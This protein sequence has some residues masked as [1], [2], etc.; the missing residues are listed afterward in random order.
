MSQTNLLRKKHLLITCAVT[1]CTIAA[2][3]VVVYAQSTPAI[4][5]MSGNDVTNSRNQPAEHVIQ[6]SNVSTLSPKWTFTTQGDVSATP[7]LDSTAVYAA[8][9]AGN[10]YAISRSAGQQLWSHSIA[11]YDGFSGS[12][13]RT[14]PAL[15]NADLIIGD[16]ESPGKTHSG[17]NVI[18]INRQTGTL[19]WITQVDA[20][21]AAE[22]TGP[23]VVAGSMIIVG[24]SSNEEGLAAQAGYACCTF[25]GSVVA[26]DGATGKILWQTYT[27]PAN[28]GQTGGYSGGAVWQPAAVDT[29]N[30]LVY[31]GVGNNYSAPQSVEDCQSNASAGERASCFDPAD[32]FDT[33][34][35]LSLASGAIRWSRTL[36][37][38][39]IWTVA[40][41]AAM[42]GTPC[43]SPAGPDFDLGG[44]GPN[45]LT[46]LLAVGQKSGMLWGLDP[47]TGAVRWGTP[48]GPG[49][50]LGGIEWGTA[51]DG[52]RIYAAI[53]NSLHNSYSLEKNG[54]AT[55]WGSWSAI[56]A[57]TGKI[58]WQTADP[59][60]GAIDP[61]AMSVA[62]G[63]VYAGSF[64]GFMY[65]M[66]ASTGRI[67]WSFDSGGSVVDG[68]SIADG[69]VYWGS[70]YSHIKP[71]KGNNK[72]YAF[73][74]A[75]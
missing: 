60:E 47:G 30:G 62:N 66:D 67:L 65:A 31:I 54:L 68:P 58:E 37:G 13:S 22:I 3:L 4:W 50:T 10:L 59:T 49:S 45:L 16:L 29:A 56:N 21:P 19:H 64:S 12:I 57:R 63:I 9:W 69:M 70:G 51:S 48:V 20:H 74:P 71:G 53:S 28:G 17:A 2:A 26:L 73:A 55:S 52:Q 72:I 8:D 35:A 34:L 39:D 23:P 1:A 43:P 18:A 15:F 27:V 24:V 25:R 7:T 61:G 14:S 5:Q 40:C 75:Q 11:Q 36:Q 41:T 32:Y 6:R 33:E 44:S 38:S 46:N 42:P